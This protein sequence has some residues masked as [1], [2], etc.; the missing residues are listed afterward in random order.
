MQWD[1][2]RQ[3]GV[4]GR[5]SC[6]GTDK[7]S[8]TSHMTMH[9]ERQTAKPQGSH[10]VATENTHLVEGGGVSGT[11]GAADVVSTAAA[12]AAAANG[13]DDDDAEGAAA[14]DVEAGGSEGVAEAEEADGVVAASAASP[15]VPDS[16]CKDI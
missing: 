8:H 2:A 9:K 1:P 14:E 10:Q 6:A 15:P 7:A 5:C 11:A 12:V 13:T 4:G 3:N 16:C